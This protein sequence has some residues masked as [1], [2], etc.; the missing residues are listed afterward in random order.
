MEILFSRWGFGGVVA[1]VFML[2]VLAEWLQS[3]RILRVA[4]LAFG[5]KGRPRSW[6][7]VIP[8]LRAACLTGIAWAL[9]SLLAIAH[10]TASSQTRATEAGAEQLVMLVDISPSMEIADAGPKAEQ[11]RSERLRDV[12][13][14]ILGRMG[15]QVRYSLLC[16]YTR[17][18]PISRQAHDKAVVANVFDGLPIY[19][20]M[21]P[22]QTDLEDALKYTLD[23]IKDFPRKSVTLMIC[24]DGDTKPIADIGELPESLKTALILG[25]GNPLDGTAIDGHL[26]YQDQVTLRELA[27]RLHGHS[28]DVNSRQLSSAALGNLCYIGSLEKNDGID[29][30]SISLGIL[31]LCTFIYTLIPLL[32]DCCGSDWK[33][34]GREVTA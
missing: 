17:T 24:T 10:S 25:V 22:G 30:Q 11:T 6:V 4:R 14:V 32:L 20:A 8:Y 23:F 34:R 16:F 21:Q 31:A 1:G 19:K 5:P 26:S 13:S 28:F 9:L 33:V 27:K 2:A 12:V 3:R 7:R 15:R 29:R 18:I